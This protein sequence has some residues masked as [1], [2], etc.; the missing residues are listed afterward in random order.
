MRKIAKTVQKVM[1]ANVR[2]FIRDNVYHLT[3]TIMIILI[4]LVQPGDAI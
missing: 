2:R 3:A 4:S 1:K